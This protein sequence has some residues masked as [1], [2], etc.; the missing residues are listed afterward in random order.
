[1]RQYLEVIHGNLKLRQIGVD[2]TIWTQAE[3]GPNPY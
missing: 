3:A 1:M 2:M